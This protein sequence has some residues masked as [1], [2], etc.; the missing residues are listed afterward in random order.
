MEFGINF[1]VMGLRFD[2]RVELNRKIA[3]LYLGI[4]RG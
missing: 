1:R 2:I 4:A 3:N